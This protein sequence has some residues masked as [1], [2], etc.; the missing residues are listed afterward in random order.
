MSTSDG[1]EYESKM[2]ISS[3][4]SSTSSSTSNPRTPPNCARCRNHRKKI[5]LKGH[6]RYCMY[7][8]CK[9]QKCQLTSE[10]QRVMAMQ[11]ALRRA[12]AQDEAMLKNGNLDMAMLPQKTPS[13]LLNVDRASLDCDSSVSS[14]CST[15][16]A[17]L[18]KKV[19]PVLAAPATS[20]TSSSMPVGL[21]S[22]VVPYEYKGHQSTDLLEDCH[23]LLEKF[24]YPWEMMPLM[25][26]IL[27]DARADLEEA[28]RRI[29][30]AYSVLRA[31][32]AEDALR[33][34]RFTQLYYRTW[35]AFHHAP[36]PVTVYHTPA[37]T[38]LG[39]VP[40]VC[41]SSP[42]PSSPH[43]LSVRRIVD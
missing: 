15:S 18:P 29:D 32:A 11:T 31:K 13:P 30:E 33:N 3:K 16:I 4:A 39:A 19:S 24:N 9:C 35:A 8:H 26:A 20:S 6:K 36:T 23:K 21:V 42:L 38:S 1:Q 43:N 40:P 2:D 14:A 37:P 28:S 41:S 27:K 7:R 22:E 34:A 25:Y 17:P 12:Q 10:R 5:A